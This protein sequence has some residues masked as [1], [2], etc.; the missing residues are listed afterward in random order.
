MST[1]A[2]GTLGLSTDEPEE[3]EKEESG[4]GKDKDRFTLSTTQHH[5]L[6]R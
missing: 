3:E 4:G 1:E 2:V 6:P 5:T